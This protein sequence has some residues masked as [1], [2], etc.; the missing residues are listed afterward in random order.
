VTSATPR[1]VFF[2]LDGTLVDP[3]EGITGSY[4]FALERLGVEVPDAKHLGTLIGPPLRGNLARL[5]G[6]SDP[7]EIERGVALFRERYTEAGWHQNVVYPGAL[8]MLD[9]L[10]A[11]GL[12]LYLT[13]A[14]PERFARRVAEHHGIAQRLDGIFGPDFDGHLD[15]KAHLVARAVERTATAA[16]AVLLVGDR[17]IDMRAARENGLSGVGVAWGYGSRDE[18]EE[19]G[20]SWV[21]EGLGDLSAL[22]LRET[23]GAEGASA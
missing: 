6:T 10:R 11:A 13:T 3:Y 17:G 14:K 21:C 9:A 7:A 18:L 19:A 16:T 22:L 23:L 2:D 20:A 5:L 15:D 4:R 12:R 8:E 1:G